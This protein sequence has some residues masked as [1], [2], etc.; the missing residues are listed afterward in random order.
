MAEVQSG[1]LGGLGRSR[2]VNPSTINDRIFLRSDCRRFAEP[3]RDASGSLSDA[4]ESDC[5]WRATAAARWV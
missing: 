1:D 4:A 3:Q 5:W 2:I